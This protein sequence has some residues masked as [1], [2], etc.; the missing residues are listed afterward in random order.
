MFHILLTS[1]S[2]SLYVFSFSVSFVLKFE[3]SGMA[4]L[5]SRQVFP[6]YNAVVNQ[7]LLL[8]SFNLW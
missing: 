7:V 6:F 4:I 3:S 1:V 5:I 2:R 8:V